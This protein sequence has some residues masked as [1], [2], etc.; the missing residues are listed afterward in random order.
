MVHQLQAHANSGPDVTPLSWPNGR[1]PVTPLV[2]RVLWFVPI[3]GW[4]AAAVWYRLRMRPVVADVCRQLLARPPAAEAWGT[5]PRR[6]E[7]GLL[8]SERIA[9]EFG[10]PDVLFFPDDPLDVLSCPPGDGLEWVVIMHAVERRLGRKVRG[11]FVER[12]DLSTW[13]LGRLVDYCLGEMP[14]TAPPA[15]RS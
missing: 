6:T 8:V 4:V 3:L 11:V 5:D 2:E 12:T 1:R 9:D 15:E 7:L 14:I 13:T 10:W